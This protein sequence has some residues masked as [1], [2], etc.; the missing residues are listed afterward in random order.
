MASITDVASPLNI[1]IET[2]YCLTVT[3][4]GSP[5]K[6]TV[7]GKL[8]GF[9]YHWNEVN[10]LKIM[11]TPKRLLSNEVWTIKATYADDTVLTE[12]VIFN[13]V[14]S[15]PIIATPERIKLYKGLKSE[16]F[17]P[18]A[19]YPNIIN[20]T[21]LLVGLT[22]ERERRTDAE[23]LLIKGEVPKTAEFSVT[24]GAFDLYAANSGGNH[25]IAAPFDIIA[26]TFYGSWNPST[27]TFYEFE[28]NGEA[29]DI[30]SNRSFTAN[31]H[32]QGYIDVDNNNIYFSRK[33]GTWYEFYRMPRNTANGTFASATRIGRDNRG[34]NYH[35]MGVAI[36][37]DNFY[38]V[39][40][41]GTSP[42]ATTDSVQV[43]NKDTW[44]RSRYFDIPSFYELDGTNV[45]L[46]PRGIVIDGDDLIF[47]SRQAHALFWV[48][49]NTQNT[50]TATI[51][52]AVPL[53]SEIQTPH[54]V[55]LVGEYLLISDTGNQKLHL[56]NSETGNVIG[57]YNLPS[58]LNRTQGIAIL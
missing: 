23:G 58:S 35:P 2:E 38:F 47:V 53:P 1:A 39:G 8:E 17:V 51:T 57:T 28:I 49:K 48:S 15:A 44:V 42:S 21:G 9:S 36:D 55:A 24:D 10:T 22:Y 5:T 54:D 30:A 37:G 43:R 29:N 25:S 12:D 26:P 6:V 3:I 45:R 46:D 33:N 34:S 56:V 19:N 41:I 14:A 16:I 32:H 13:V 27:D 52:K 4:T 7:E 31:R 50:Q 18:I 40:L 20:A 11:G